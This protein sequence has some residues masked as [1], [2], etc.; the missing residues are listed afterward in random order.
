MNHVFDLEAEFLH[1]FD[2]CRAATMTS[3]ERMYAL[4]RATCHVIDQDVPGDLVECGVWRG[5]S[6]MLMAYTLLARGCTDRT[7]WLYDTFDGMPPPGDEDVQ[8]MTGRRAREIL[9]ERERSQDD[10]F[11]GIAPRELVE[12][13]LRR[14]R[15]PMHRFRFV[16]GDVMETI[17]AEAPLSLSVLRLDT[18]WYQSTKH[19]LEQLYPRLS[20]GGVLIVDDYGY[21]RGAR[22]ATDEYFQTL[23]ARP[24]LNRIDYTGRICV[25]P[26]EVR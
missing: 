21:W 8:E 6:V 12:R 14:T 16:E 7:I 23:K 11:W 24:L 5:G 25:K 17:P 22:R 19:E 3:I 13:N 15:Y 9:D 20:P 26:F 10:P 1:L 4:Y 2:S 18:D